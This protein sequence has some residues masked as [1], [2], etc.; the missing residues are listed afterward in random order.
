MVLV[1]VRKQG[2]AA[3][4]TIPS[5]ILRLLELGVGMKLELDVKGQSLVAKK[6]LETTRKRYSISEL[7]EGATKENM[8]AL[9]E[10]TDWAREG[11]ALGGE[12]E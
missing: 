1:E 10:Q 7:L 2:G 3:V 6:A 4:I 8:E 9:N 12:L 5:A 11:N